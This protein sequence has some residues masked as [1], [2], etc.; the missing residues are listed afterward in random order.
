MSDNNILISPTRGMDVAVNTPVDKGLEEPGFSTTRIDMIKDLCTDLL[1]SDRSIHKFGLFTK[2]IHL[3]EEDKAAVKLIKETTDPCSIT[4]VE[5][6]VNA[7]CALPSAYIGAITTVDEPPKV[8]EADIKNVMNSTFSPELPSCE[9]SEKGKG[10]MVKERH[11]H[12]EISEKSDNDVNCLAEP[13]AIGTQEE[14][15]YDEKGAVRSFAQQ[16]NAEVML[17]ELE[18]EIPLKAIHHLV[19]QNDFLGLKVGSYVLVRN[20]NAT[21]KLDQKFLGPLEVIEQRDDA[22]EHIFELRDLVQDT[23]R[24]QHLRNLVPLDIGYESALRAARQNA[25]EHIVT[26]V[27]GHSGDPRNV[28]GIP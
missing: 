4:V 25:G 7:N 3:S 10:A 12:E 28:A 26:G 11:Y 15:E 9:S 22:N 21:S 5:E 27:T 2:Q 23:I 20:N 16:D 13:S 18:G 19:E 6:I 8:I 14:N 24:T 17:K 1:I